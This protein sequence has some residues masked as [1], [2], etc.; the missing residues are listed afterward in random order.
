M[1]LCSYGILKTVGVHGEYEEFI[2]G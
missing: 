1:Y 2:Q